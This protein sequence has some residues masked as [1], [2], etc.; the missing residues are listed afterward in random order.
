LK[1]LTERLIALKDYQLNQHDHKEVILKA[2][3]ALIEF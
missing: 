3:D 1:V 2:I